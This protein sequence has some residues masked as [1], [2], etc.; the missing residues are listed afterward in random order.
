MPES[1]SNVD[2]VKGFLRAQNMEQVGKTDEAI[3]LYEG[4]VREGFDSTGPYDRL[5]AIYSARAEHS[6]VVRVA[7]AALENVKTYEDKRGWYARMRDEAERAAA[8]VP[9]PAPRR[10]G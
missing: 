2:L 1:P 8:A 10:P 9:K 3:A 5:I 6:Q 7:K 4:A